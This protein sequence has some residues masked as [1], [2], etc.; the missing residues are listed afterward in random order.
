M[1]GNSTVVSTGS[2]TVATTGTQTGRVLTRLN[3]LITSSNAIANPTVYDPTV[4]N[5]SATI[6]E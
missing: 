3:A 5:G 2:A 1:A 6:A 4:S